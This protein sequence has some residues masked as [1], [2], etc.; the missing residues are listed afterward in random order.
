A[1]QPTPAP[2]A[3]GYTL[4]KELYDRA[5]AYSREEHEVYFV[6]VA[7]GALLLI[8]ILAARWGPRF[9]DAAE[10]AS[11]FR[12]VQAVVFT[13]ILT[14]VLAILRLPVSTYSHWLSLSYDQSVQSW[15]SWIWDAAKSELIAVVIGSFIVWVMYG[16]IRRSPRRWWFYFWLTTIPFTVFTAIVEPVFIAP[17]FFTFE[18]LQTRQPALAA[19]IE[20]VAERGGLTIEQSRMFEMNA[21]DKMKSLNAYVTGF[22][23][24]KRV[25]VY[26]TTIAKMTTPQILFIFG[27]EMGHYVLGHIVKGM[28][29]AEVTLL[30]G[31]YLAFLWINREVSRRGQ[32]WGIRG[33]EDWAS[34]PALMLFAAVSSF[35]MTP[36]LNAYSRHDE[37]QADVYGLE[38]THS[39]VPDSGEVA[40]QAFQVLGEADLG[41]PNPSPFVKFWFLDH[42]SLNDRILF[43]RSYD[44]WS[45]GEPPEFVR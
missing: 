8:V 39:I 43:A 5:V 33:V 21:S 16:I 28:V 11:R 29:V 7:Y 45:K 20:R 37:H 6:G 19:Q 38:V 17:L 31:L 22:G 24:S 25:V 10:R 32:R 34:L 35:L 4:S 36:A 18:P 13:S 3:K 14:I 26:D 12:F 40:A 15:P 42:P 30:V 1:R 27:H 23:P 44:P 41:D 2:E 9:R